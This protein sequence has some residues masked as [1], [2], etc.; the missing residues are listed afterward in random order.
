MTELN[1]HNY[2]FAYK[3]RILR[4]IPRSES[5]Q[6]NIFKETIEWSDKIGTESLRFSDLHE[7]G[8]F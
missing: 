8:V 3:D 1:R 7:R 2:P 4:L 5:Q 6:F